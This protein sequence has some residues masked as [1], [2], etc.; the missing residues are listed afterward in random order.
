MNF[1]GEGIP[2][3]YTCNLKAPI[4]NL[5]DNFEVSGHEDLQIPISNTFPDT[6]NRRNC[7]SVVNPHG[8]KSYPIL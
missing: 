5:S 4:G 8:E 7:D 6:P 1:S 3:L 2:I